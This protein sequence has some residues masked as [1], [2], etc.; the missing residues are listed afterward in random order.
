VLAAALM[1]ACGE[2]ES[3]NGFTNADDAVDPA[4]VGFWEIPVPGGRW[5]LKIEPYGHYEFSNVSGSPAPS[6]MGSFTARD[7]E[8]TLRSVSGIED[9]GRYDVLDGGIELT[10]NRG[11]VRWG[12]G[13]ALTRVTPGVD[14]GTSA[15]PP[16]P[17]ALGAGVQQPAFAGGQPPQP[18]QPARP[19]PAAIDTPAP[20]TAA[21][22]SGGNIPEIVDPCLLVT[23]DE[24]GKLFGAPAT[25]KRT[26]P[27]P[28][29]QNDCFYSGAGGL[30]FTVR[31][32]NGKGLD[33]AAYI[34][35]R[36]KEGGV[37]IA[38]I[39]DRAVQSYREATG[40]VSVDFVIGATS[41]SLLVAGVEPNRAQPAMIELARQAADRLT[42][43][44]S[45]YD[46]GG[47]ER[48]VGAWRVVTHAKDSRE[49]IPDAIILV[50]RN[51]DVTFETS[52]VASGT[53]ELEGNTWRLEKPYF[54]GLPH[55]TYRLR[56]NELTLA[57]EVLDVKLERVACGKEPNV[58]PPYELGR[59]LGG[60]MLST[61]R[62]RQDLR[63]PESKTLDKNLIGLWDGEGK[64][65]AFGVA[66]RLLMA[67]DE[68]GYAVL[69]FFPHTKG[70]LEVRNG[71]Y[72]LVL[73]GEPTR[74]GTYSFAGGVN[75]G[76]IRMQDG[77]NTLEWIPTDPSRHPVFETPIVARCG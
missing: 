44:S 20:V 1:A 60:Q 38:A 58:L 42:S 33:P 15:V 5:T 11:T 23:A 16:Q 71:E 9:R 22:T 31:S 28:R 55:G 48:F 59:T 56:G 52:A 35:R 34:E 13:V 72:T 4:L 49:D 8:W 46:M 62:L 24:V 75:D 76:I 2:D 19:A 68:R 7:G 63:P 45:A 43:M 39:G 21:R 18:A 66:T 3:A 53:L 61:S 50:A 26:T 64:F 14:A 73:E 74:K 12:P 6:H 67:V 57:G 17:A 77:E 37:P 47:V 30:S 51:G 10:G 27:Q 29:T 70:R 25:A 36:E 69:A 41:V 54:E 40:L 65:V 32:F